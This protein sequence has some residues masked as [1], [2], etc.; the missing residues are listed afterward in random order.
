MISNV[1]AACLMVEEHSKCFQSSLSSPPIVSLT[2]Y[3]GEKEPMWR[4]CWCFPHSHAERANAQRDAPRPEATTALT[5]PCANLLHSHFGSSRSRLGSPRSRLGS[6]R[7]HLGSPRSHLGSSRSRLVSP[8]SR[9]ESSRSH[10]GSPKSQLGS[11][12]SQLGSPRSQLRSPRS[13]LG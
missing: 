1:R 13:Q 10:L 9:L 11:P 2:D 4:L 8:R 3:Q 6:S 7:S 12:R 5:E